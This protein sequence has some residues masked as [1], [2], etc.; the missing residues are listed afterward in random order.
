MGEIYAC[1]H[2]RF[3]L[4]HLVGGKDHPV[5]DGRGGAAFN[6][7]IILDG[8]AHGQWIKGVCLVRGCGKRSTHSRS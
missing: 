2:K 4:H 5:Q 6:V 7:E 8:R 1:V 3:D